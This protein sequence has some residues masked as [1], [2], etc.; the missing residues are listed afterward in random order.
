M[1]KILLI[2]LL[3]PAV[4]FGQKAPKPNTKKILSLY[5]DGKYKEAKEQADIS[6]ADPKVG[7]DGY[8]WYYRGL[9]YAT[10]DTIN[11]ASLKSLEAEPRKVALESF[12]KAEDLNKKKDTEYFVMAPGTYTPVNKSQQLEQWSNWYLGKSIKMLQ[13]EEPDYNGSYANGKIAR[14]IFENYMS[15]YPNDTLTYYVQSLAAINIMHYDSAEEAALKY[16]EK[17]GKNPDMYLILFQIYNDKGDKV[18]ALEIAK[19][20]REK[21]PFREDFA[22]NELNVYLTTKQFDAAKAMV[23]EQVQTDPSAETYYLLGEL[24]KEL[25]NK[26]EALKAYGK[27]LELDANHFDTNASMAEMT[28]AEVGEVRKE[29]D[30]TK[31]IA[32]R[33]E[34]YQ[35][36]AQE[37]RET[38]P[39]WE[40]LEALKPNDENVLYGLQSIYNDLSAYDEAKY[41]AKLKKLKAK[42]KALNLEVD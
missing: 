42:M 15:K 3:A 41:S 22:K 19:E 26:P 11:D 20:G 36:I 27:A 16:R 9:V 39:Y 24:N 35:K 32:K 40:K 33:Q 38:V 10:L 21:F 4:V 2:L 5:Q 18:K 12:Q 17:G 8:A 14:S 34:L 29:R 31:D 23:E 6:V 37:L 25:K 7:L 1:K 13:M 30:A 28:Y